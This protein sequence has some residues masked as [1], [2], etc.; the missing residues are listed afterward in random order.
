MGREAADVVLMWSNQGIWR[1]VALMA[2]VDENSK[3][4]NVVLSQSMEPDAVHAEAV[5]C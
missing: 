5:F 3:I 2:V 1:D 4:R